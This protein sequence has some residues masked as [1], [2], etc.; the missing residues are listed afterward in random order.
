MNRT[1]TI[2]L[3][4]AAL[5]VVVLFVVAIG[6][7]GGISSSAGEA[8]V[9]R[10]PRPHPSSHLAITAGAIGL[11]NFT[12]HPRPHPQSHIELLVK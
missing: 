1:H 12:R 2:R 10:L 9:L 3:I 8:T 11:D 7:P 6:L 5:V 4:S